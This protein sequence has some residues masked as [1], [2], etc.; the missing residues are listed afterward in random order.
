MSKI[1]K[2]S[3]EYLAKNIKNRIKSVK[4]LNQKTLAS[5]L[6]YT[7]NEFSRLL[8]TQKHKN[9]LSK[10]LEYLDQ[11]YPENKLRFDL[12]LE[13]TDDEESPLDLNLP[14]PDE[15]LSILE[16]DLIQDLIKKS[17]ISDDLKKTLVKKLANLSLD[18]F[19]K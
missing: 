2:D 9:K 3:I 5:K 12:D 15:L 1:A 10:V 19:Y 11:N 7:E 17:K 13:I 8:S 14:T 6:N 16:L 4:S 18:R